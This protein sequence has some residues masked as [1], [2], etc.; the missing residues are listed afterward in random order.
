MGQ[1]ELVFTTVVINPSDGGTV[2]GLPGMLTTTEGLDFSPAVCSVL[3]FKIS[4]IFLRGEGS[5][6][7]GTVGNP[8]QIENDQG[9]LLCL[10]HGQSLVFESVL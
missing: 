2:Q 7:A 3:V 10:P 6:E 8:W 4:N 1:K 9:A 5:K